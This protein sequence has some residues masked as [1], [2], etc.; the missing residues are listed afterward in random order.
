[1]TQKDIFVGNSL[2]EIYDNIFHFY[3]KGVNFLSTT[4]KQYGDKI[5]YTITVEPKHI[6]GENKYEDIQEMIV[7]KLNSVE[8]ELSRLES[9]DKKKNSCI[10][11]KL[12]EKLKGKLLAKGLDYEWLESITQSGLCDD[13]K[14]AINYMIDEIECNIS[15]NNNKTNN[16]PKII[17]MVGTTGVGKTTTIAKLAAKFKT[18]SCDEVDI[19]FLNLDHYRVASSEQLRMYASMA[20]ASYEDIYDSS[21]LNDYLQLLP[22]NSIVFIDTA[23]ASPM[24]IS[25]I[26]ETISYINN[27]NNIEIEISL[28]MPATFKKEDLIY[29]YNHFSFLNLTSLIITKFDET[30]SITGLVDFLR[31]CPTK[32]DYFTIGQKV[33]NDIIDAD[34]N[35]IIEKLRDEW[36]KLNEK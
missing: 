6:L 21:A 18:N 12:F 28:V 22:K 36:L 30:S 24:D 14:L 7:E 33:P 20:G 8:M 35:Y 25:K 31:T 23:G 15:I 2:V 11:N 9:M 27:T 1:M 34:S 26:L 5:E 32:L 4:H 17:M 19:S 10:E 16:Y 3:P 29:A 13:I